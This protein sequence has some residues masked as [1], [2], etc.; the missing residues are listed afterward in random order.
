MD[1]SMVAPS[2]VR[3]RRSRAARIAWE[4]YMPDAMSAVGIPV[5]TG[6]SG[7]PVIAMSPASAWM[8]MS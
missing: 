8:S 5:L 3:H 1:T 2:P 6:V 4:Q 7:V